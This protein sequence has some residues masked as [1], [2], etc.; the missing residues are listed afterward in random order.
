MA[1]DEAGDHAA[2]AR[3]EPGVARRAGALD[4]GHQPVLD[5]QSRVARLYERRIPRLPGAGHQQPDVVYHER[6]HASTSRSSRGTSSD[7]CAPPRTIQR[8]PTTTSRTS[9]APP[10]NTS[11]STAASAGVPAR[12]TP[13]SDPPHRSASA[14]TA[15]RPA[16]GQP[17]A[18]WPA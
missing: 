11:D 17:S 14:P 9:P 1:V 6:A 7:T 16:S 15:S 10:A 5:D 3:V 18:A 2:P 13:S 4:S 12:R 8:P